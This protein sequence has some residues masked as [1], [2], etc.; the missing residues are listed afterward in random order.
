MTKQ[1]AHEILNRCRDGEPMSTLV[2]NQALYATG[3]IFGLFGESLRFDGHEQRH[4]RP[5]QAHEQ[6]T[7]VGFSYSKYLD[8]S[9]TEGVTQ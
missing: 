8:Y 9:K 6:T 3:D 1:Q 7:I 2:T 4:D 5:R